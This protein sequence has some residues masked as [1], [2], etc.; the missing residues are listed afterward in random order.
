MFSEELV[1]Q[2]RIDISFIRE[3]EAKLAGKKLL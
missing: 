2:L 1:A 3:L